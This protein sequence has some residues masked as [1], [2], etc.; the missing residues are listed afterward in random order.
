[1]RFLAGPEGLSKKTSKLRDI[2]TIEEEIG[3]LLAEELEAERK[4]QWR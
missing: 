2:A 1:M 3:S 4:M